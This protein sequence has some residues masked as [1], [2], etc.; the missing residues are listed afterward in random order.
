[1]KI[2]FNDSVE[3]LIELRKTVESWMEESAKAIISFRDSNVEHHFKTRFDDNLNYDN[4]SEYVTIARCYT[5]LLYLCRNMDCEELSA[6]KDK[7]INYLNDFKIFFDKTKINQL[8]ELLN[9]NEFENTFAMI[10]LA[11]FVLI[12]NFTDR[13]HAEGSTEDKNILIVALKAKMKDM[14]ELTQESP[15]QFL[16]TKDNHRTNHF[17][18]TLHYLRAQRILFNDDELKCE[19]YES[20]ISDAEKFCLEQC[21]YH[22]RGQY[23]HFDATRLACASTIYLLY[24]KHIDKEL[25]VAVLEVLANTQQQDG[26]WV[27]AH[28]IV[29]EKNKHWYNPFH[30]IPL[31]LTWQYFQP[32]LLDSARHKLLQILELHF[33]RYVLPSYKRTQNNKG[34][35]DNQSNSQ[36]EVLGWATGIVAHFIANYYNVLNDH[37][38][39]K[40]VENLNLSADAER[41]TIDETDRNQNPKWK[42]K[43]P[44]PSVPP[45]KLNKLPIWFDLPPYA[46]E[47][48][49]VEDANIEVEIQKKWTDPSESSNISKKLA[50]HVIVPIVNDRRYRPG[51]NRAGIFTGPPGT[52]KTSLVRSISEILE[53]PLITVPASVFFK[54][55]FDKLE[56]QAS[57][58]FYLLGHLSRCV[59]FFDEF[60]E[61]MRDRG[62]KDKEGNNNEA[63]NRTI[64]AFTTSAMLPRFQALHDKQR[65]LYFLA[66]NHLPKI[67]EAII[68]EGRFDFKAEISH[69]TIGRLLKESGF[70]KNL[71]DKACKKFEPK[72]DEKN[73]IHAVIDQLTESYLNKYPAVLLESPITFKTVEKIMRT[74]LDDVKKATDKN[75]IINRIIKEMGRKNPSDPDAGPPD[76]LSMS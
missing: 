59:I 27:C 74:I 3:E 49:K 51:T 44:E 66:T 43:C 61:F 65:S 7:P 55:G 40:I 21:Y 17:L 26:T 38:N 50:K 58:V 48:A 60:E 30:E 19:N 6:S 41:F 68:R 52:R 15:G 54:E 32:R 1:M 11:D 46:W 14:P 10:R 13:F 53:W 57:N 42:M 39:R 76:L 25:S 23:H 4:L 67:D 72:V 73:N 36:N 2:P 5:S 62:G 22:Q 45:A 9:K 29:R 16:L 18:I 69:P 12:Q 33:T 28:P 20:I 63:H 75:E 71:A 24:G 35:N 56:A 37:I 8:T 31:C 34:W 70:L 64:A 47:T